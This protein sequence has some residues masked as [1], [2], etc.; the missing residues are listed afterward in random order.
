MTSPG[1]RKQ[2]VVWTSNRRRAADFAQDWLDYIE[3]AG[4][5][6]DAQVRAVPLDV[7][8]EEGALVPSGPLEGARR[9]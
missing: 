9:T 3:R 2:F 4:V 8:L 6:V 5:R 1:G 7:R